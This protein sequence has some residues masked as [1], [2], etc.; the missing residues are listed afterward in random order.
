MA[1]SQKVIKTENF[2]RLLKDVRQIIKHPLIDNGI[3]YSHDESD[4]T[5][6][7]AMII[8]PPDTPYFGGFY[9]FYF[10]YPFDYPF[11]PPKVKYMTNDGIT[12]F[13]PNLYRSGKVCVS[14]LNTWTGDTWSSCQT[15][16]SVLLTLCSLLNDA[17]LENEPEQTKPSIGFIPYQKTIEYKNID[18]AICDLI[19]RSKINK[20]P[21]H[22]EIF[23]PFMK[24]HFLTNYD[25][26]LNFVRNKANSTESISTQ[27][28]HIYKMR[29]EINY[30]NL[31][32]KLITTK[33]IIDSEHI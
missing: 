5:K 2:K 16:N 14:I 18:F 1:E 17:P 31:E 22:F 24:Q 20:I 6:G 28:V 27:V 15:I 7:Y 9:F 11:S 4:M 10:D 30:T 8:G 29:T 21:T 26:I 12:R 33:K 3:Y 13:N 32:K 25:T 19:N 23:Y